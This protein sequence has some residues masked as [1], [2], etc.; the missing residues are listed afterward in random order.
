MQ[1]GITCNVHKVSL[2]K[3]HEI[4]KWARVKYKA[5]SNERGNDDNDGDRQVVKIENII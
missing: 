5:M 1:H 4:Q 2:I 3:Y